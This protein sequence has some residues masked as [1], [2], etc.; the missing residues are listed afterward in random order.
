VGKQES[1]VDPAAAKSLDKIP[2][3]PDLAGVLQYVDN[4]FF[5][6]YEYHSWCVLHFDS[7]LSVSLI[8]LQLQALICWVFP[9]IIH[10]PI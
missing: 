10:F 6:R 3:K 1:S 9:P 7:E 8:L 2:S 5:L 4:G